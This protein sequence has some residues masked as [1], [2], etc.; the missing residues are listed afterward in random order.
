M[1]TRPQKFRE[2]VRLCR[3]NASLFALKGIRPTVGAMSRKAAVEFSKGADA[4]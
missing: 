2:A 1:P 3:L 4:N